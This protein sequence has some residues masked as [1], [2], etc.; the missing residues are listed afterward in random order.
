MPHL[1]LGMLSSSVKAQVQTG[2]AE[3]GVEE[4]EVELGEITQSRRGKAALVE[5]VA[6]AGSKTGKQV[7]A[8]RAA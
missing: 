1:L 4:V 2:K 5:Q 7:K 3:R 8:E 6:V